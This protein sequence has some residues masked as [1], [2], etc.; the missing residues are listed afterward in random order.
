MRAFRERL[1]DDPEFVRW[2]K[3]AIR[4]LDQSATM[5]GI[6]DDREEYRFEFALQIGHCLMKDKPI[7]II[8]PIGTRIPPKLEAAA[9]AIEYFDRAIGKASVQAAAER[10]LSRIGITRRH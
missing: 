6:L 3:R 4:G 10:A 1:S 5:L 9:T 2:A 7:V 8:A